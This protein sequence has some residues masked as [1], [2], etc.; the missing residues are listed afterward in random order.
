MTAFVRD[1]WGLG[2]L[3]PVDNLVHPEYRA[4]GHVVGRSFV[5]KNVARFYTAFPDLSIEMVELIEKDN[6]VAVLIE[7]F[8]ATREPHRQ[9]SKRE[10]FA[11]NEK[12]PVA[13]RGRF[14]AWLWGFLWVPTGARTRNL[15]LHRQA[16]CRLSYKHHKLM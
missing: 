15:L 14:S 9:G 13:M 16:L 10:A 5:R 6:R 4:D 8:M 2:D 7:L 1:V 3:S 11:G 12:R